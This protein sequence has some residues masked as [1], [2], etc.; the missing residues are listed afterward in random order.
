MEPAQ[1]SSLWTRGFDAPRNNDDTGLNCG[2][3]WVSCNV[4]PQSDR[5]YQHILLL[6]YVDFTRSLMQYQLFHLYTSIQRSEF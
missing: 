2:G 3:A 1:R 6:L 4:Y 5:Y